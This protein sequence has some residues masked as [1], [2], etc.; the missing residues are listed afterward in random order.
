MTS[1]TSPSRMGLA[2]AKNLAH[3][4]GIVVG[5]HRGFIRE[6]FVCRE[7][8]GGP[9]RCVRQKK[10][11]VSGSL[12]RTFSA[13]SSNPFRIVSSCPGFVRM[14]AVMVIMTPLALGDQGAL[15]PSRSRGASVR[16]RTMAYAKRNSLRAGNS[17][18]G[19]S[20]PIGWKWRRFGE[21]GEG[22]RLKRQARVRAVMLA[23]EAGRGTVEGAPRC[24]TGRRARSKTGFIVRPILWRT[25]R[26]D[27]RQA[28]LV[29]LKRRDEVGWS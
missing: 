22:L 8:A 26:R 11:M 19:R 4:L 12:R 3:D 1:T 17:S 7:E 16:A 28:V 14:I 5:V 23:V 21:S 25:Q 20:T 15:S 29:P 27:L 6:S 10:L 13:T 24:R 9:Q 18:S 2:I